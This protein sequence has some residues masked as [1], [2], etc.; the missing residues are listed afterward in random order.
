MWYFLTTLWEG[1]RLP[2]SLLLA[3]ILWITVTPW[4]LSILAHGGF[5]CLASQSFTQVLV[6]FH[7]GFFDSCLCSLSSSHL[8]WGHGM[9]PYMA[10]VEGST[11]VVGAQFSKKLGR[12]FISKCCCSSTCCCCSGLQGMED[13]FL[14]HTIIWLQRRKLAIGWSSPGE[15]KLLSGS[16]P[17]GE[18]R[19]VQGEYLQFIHTLI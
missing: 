11:P 19:N 4:A 12:H 13:H 10:C 7:G 1:V 17:Y 8:F 6:Y 16:V 3:D 9:Y 5:L 15:I 2:L 18:P 14:I